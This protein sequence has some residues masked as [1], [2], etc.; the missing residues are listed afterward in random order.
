MRLS[1]AKVV[2]FEFQ[3]AFGRKLGWLNET[4]TTVKIPIILSNSRKSLQTRLNILNELIAWKGFLFY[5]NV[6]KAK[7]KQ[8]A[9]LILI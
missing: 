9:L 7:T 4:S 3:V 2:V 8:L 5:L 6:V 1:L